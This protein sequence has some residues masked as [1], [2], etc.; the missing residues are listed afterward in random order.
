MTQTDI[1]RLLGDRGV[2]PT[3]QRMA[4]YAYLYDHRIHPSAETVYE[5]LVKEHPTFSR[6]TVYNSLH[7]LVKAGL[8]KEL[9]MDTEERHYDAD[10][11]LHGHFHCRGCG[12]IADFPLN[13]GLVQRLMPDGFTVEDQGI[14]FSGRCAACGSSVTTASN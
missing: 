12:A 11:A 7:A 6:T 9:A 3:A 2:R 1:A 13:E 4:V 10:I 14:Y 8:V 5:A